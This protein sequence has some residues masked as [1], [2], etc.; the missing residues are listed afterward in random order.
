MVL[1]VN[2]IELLIGAFAGAVGGLATEA[3]TN[4]FQSLFSLFSGFGLV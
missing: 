1:D 2:I 3:A 4:F